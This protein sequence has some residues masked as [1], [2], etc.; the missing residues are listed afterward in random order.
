MVMTALLSG[1]TTMGMLRT[2]LATAILAVTR[3]S[4]ATM[5]TRINERPRA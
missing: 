5:T 1:R 4:A 2:A 3:H